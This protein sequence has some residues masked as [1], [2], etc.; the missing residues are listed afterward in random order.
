MR[1]YLEYYTAILHIEM[2]NNNSYFYHIQNIKS[3]IQ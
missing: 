2:K 1:Y 3:K